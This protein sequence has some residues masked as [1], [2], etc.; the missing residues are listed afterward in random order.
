MLDET[1]ATAV[2]TCGAEDVFGPHRRPLWITR[3]LNQ[4]GLNGVFL[5]LEEHAVQRPLPRDIDQREPQVLNRP[6]RITRIC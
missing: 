2:I 6:S 1:E 3:N 4:K 5:C